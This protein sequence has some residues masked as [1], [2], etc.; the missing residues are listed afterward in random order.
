[1]ATQNLNGTHKANGIT[2][3]PPKHP[4]GNGGGGGGRNLGENE[5]PLLDEA[6]RRYLNYALSVIT[7]RALPDVRDGLKPV[8][9][10]I[11]YGMFHNEHVTP[12]AK[13]K[14]CAKVVGTVMGT[15]H[16]H[17]DSAI[18]EALV[19]M[20]Q[21]WSLRSP[22]V[23]GQG[24]F[25]SLDGDS[26]AAQRYT[27]C[28]LLPIAMELLSEIK[29][30]TVP[31]RQNYDGTTFEP[32]VLPARFPQL[33]V[34]GTSG[35]AVG[36]ATSIPSHNLSEVV[37]ALIALIDDSKLETK[38]LLK[39]IKG[40]DFPTGGWVINSKAEL[41]T[42]YETGQGSI[43][44]RG[45]WKSEEDKKGK[46][47]LVITSIPYAVTKS[48]L[49]EQIAEII[50]GKKVPQLLDV[51]DESTTDV[52]IVCELKK[53][54][55]PALV[56]AYLYKHTSLQQSFNVNLTCLVP[57][58]NP[59]IQAP[60]RLDL[61]AML[62]HF[63]DFR[64][65]VVTKRFQH[66]LDELQR[67]I[68]LLEAFEKAYDVLDELIKMIRKSEGKEDAAKQIMARF[69]FDEEQ[70]EAILEMKLYKLARL[71]ILAIQTELKE[72]NSEANRIGALLKSK[73]KLWGVVKSELGDIEKTYA[74]K[75]RT[76]V[77]GAGDEPEF[78]PEAYIVNEDTKVLLSRDGWVKRV[79]EIKDLSSTRLREGDSL[80]AV[81]AGSTKELVV[82][83]TNFG[84]AY[85]SRIVDIPATTGYGEPMQKLFKFDDGEQAIAMLSLDPRVLFPANKEGK[86]LLMAVKKDGM[87]MRFALEPHMEIST[88]SGR[89]FA[90][91]EV[92][93]EVVGVM[94]VFEKETL[95]VASKNAHVL[96]CPA[97]EVNELAGVGKGVT[98]IKLEDGDH[99]IGFTLTKDKNVGLTVETDSGRQVTITPGNHEVTSRGGKGHQVFKKSEVKYVPPSVEL[100]ELPVQGTA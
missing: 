21:D 10:R 86:R 59:E 13:F 20:A 38:D 34:N 74:T 48:T 85:V 16:P 84:A 51:R 24:N 26:P 63:L 25:G 73:A 31:Y 83:F 33:L 89:K 91:A 37:Q 58:D 11:L 2:K 98:A 27:E 99:V 65:E 54:T 3:P 44:T 80:V 95:I 40:P 62:R 47:Y 76:K 50:N 79:R 97:D 94:P 19:R 23:D 92:G 55:D 4:D 22:L 68:H 46:L 43:K 14:K 8:Q 41:R 56:A 90:K 30:K 96:L 29:S 12:D 72:K 64:L 57:T 78:D 45:E 61:K 18:Y 28:K 36:L 39:F 1:M 49:V 87:A 52:R 81:A 32:I 69:K 53:E 17:G 75:R 5:I 77:S 93:S 35:I 71:E 88:R 6:K 67:R 82:F 15:Y 9:R 7:S 70:T 42:I 66:Q 60:E 100:T